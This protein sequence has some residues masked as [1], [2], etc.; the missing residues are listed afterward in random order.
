MGQE[1]QRGMLKLYV[2]SIAMNLWG[3]DLLQQWNKINIPQNQKQ[4]KLTYG[5]G[6]F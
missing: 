4:N 3:R 1:E 2:T 5:S 6:K